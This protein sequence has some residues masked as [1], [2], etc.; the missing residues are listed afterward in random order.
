MRISIGVEKV[1]RSAARDFHFT[2]TFSTSDNRVVLFGPS[3]SGKTLTLR[4]IAG[5][6]KP[7]S[8]FISVDGRVLFDSG[9]KVFVPPRERKI[10]YVF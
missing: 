9:K 4:S 1:F 2:A 6:M 3:G 5:L 8:G 10:G 7:D